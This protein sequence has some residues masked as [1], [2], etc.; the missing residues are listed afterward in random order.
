MLS[1]IGALT[2]RIARL[3]RANRRLKL[4]GLGVLLASV[5]LTSMGL[6]GKPRTIEAEKIVILDS[7]GRARLTIGTPKVT[8]ATVDVKPDE[9]AIW[10]SDETGS[11][12]TVLTADGLYLA[13]TRGKPLVSIS[14]GQN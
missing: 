10:L 9:P 7:H 8:G 1:D 11:D 6:S 12:R 2:L 5:A 14:S 13:N 3:E 4:I